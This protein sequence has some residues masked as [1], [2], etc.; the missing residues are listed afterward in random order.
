[1]PKKR[2]HAVRLVV[3]NSVDDTSIRSASDRST[4]A[5]RAAASKGKKCRGGTPRCLHFLN[6]SP[7]TPI[8]AARSR[9]MVHLSIAKENGDISSPL[10]RPNS[11]TP[12]R[13]SKIAPEGRQCGMSTSD[14]ESDFN[15]VFRAR[16]RRAREAANL[17]QQ[18]V[19]TAL[20]VA[21][22]TYKK[23]ENRPTSAVPREKLL[24]FCIVTRVKCEDLLQQ[25]SPQE[26][27]LLKGTEKK[28]A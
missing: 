27:T 18:D 26:L 16:T 14:T 12:K 7:S 28:S 25:P 5:F 23:W 2:H 11:S 13:P 20:G 1:M 4:S 22:D 9:K 3:D 8:S 19:A 17:T 6:A 21:L 10:S 24:A 15:A